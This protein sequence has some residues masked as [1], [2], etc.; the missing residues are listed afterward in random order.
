MADSAFT[1]WWFEV[2]TATPS[3]MLRSIT[4]LM[5]AIVSPLLWTLVARLA[6]GSPVRQPLGSAERS[7]VF[8]A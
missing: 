8:G 6:S 2:I 4:S 7:G 1:G 5:A 3:S